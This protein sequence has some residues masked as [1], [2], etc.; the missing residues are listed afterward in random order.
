MIIGATGLLSV[1]KSTA[2]F[3]KFQ[4]TSE[5]LSLVSAF[6][7]ALLAEN[8]AV[9]TFLIQKDQKS[10]DELTKYQKEASRLM[11]QL[12]TDLKG[13]SLESQLVNLAQRKEDYES[14]ASRVVTLILEENKLAAETLEPAG[15]GAERW[16]KQLFDKLSLDNV[17]S[18]MGNSASATRKFLL[19]RFFVYRLRIFVQTE[20]L[21]RA[22]AEFKDL[23]P[24]LQTMEGLLKEDAHV[25]RL[26]KFKDSVVT[27]NRAFEAL[28]S[29]LFVRDDLVR[30]SL[31]II[32]PEMLTLA[33]ELKQ[34]ML[35]S[36]RALRDELSSANSTA[37]QTVAV[38]MALACLLGGAAAWFITRG[39]TGP[40]NRTIDQLYAATNEISSAAN[41]IASSS[42]NLATGTGEQA[43]SIQNTSKSLDEI[44]ASAKENVDATQTAKQLAQET[45][46]SAD[47]GVNEMANMSKAMDAIKRSSEEVS[48][49]VREI[50]DIAFQTNLLALNAAVEAARAGDA[51]KGFAVV[52]EEVRNLA[53]R[54]A[55]SAKETSQ[56]IQACVDCSSEGVRVSQAVFKQLHRIVEMVSKVDNL[57][58]KVSKASLEQSGNVERITDSITEVNRVTQKNAAGAE[59]SAAA[60]EELSAQA[61]TLTDVARYLN[62]LVRGRSS[63]TS[64]DHLASPDYKVGDMQH[65]SPA[66]SDK[67]GPAN[68]SWNG[69]L[70]SSLH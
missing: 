42:Q 54:S 52:A 64:A 17:V 45:R 70:E 13:S 24:I 38:V 16:S 69:G 68:G 53:Q 2:G 35:A 1:T 11:N 57:L 22:R 59:E 9:T 58:S 29:N 21:D 48:S 49:I 61:N 28:Q 34:A 65:T 41:Y 8:N 3:D 63:I 19:A 43:S 23:T 37:E 12:K 18:G 47:D 27:F 20:Y 32:G 39:I 14:V 51:G 26:N 10:L 55:S 46:S 44:S 60:A 66:D 67:K 36:Q 56:R 30:N 15:E 40:L 4:V 6:E 50:D 25:S 7:A 5:R 31:A 33:S 62:T